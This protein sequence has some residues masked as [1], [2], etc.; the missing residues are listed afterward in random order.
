MPSQSGTIRYVRDLARILRAGKV[1]LR[2]GLG[3]S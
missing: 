2:F 3:L 1:L